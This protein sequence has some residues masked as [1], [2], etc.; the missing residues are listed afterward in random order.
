VSEATPRR[1][2]CDECEQIRLGKDLDAAATTVAFE[3][4]LKKLRLQQ[5]NDLAKLAAAQINALDIA[6][7][8]AT[9]DFQKAQWAAESE[10]NKLF[11]QTVS[12]VARNSIERSRDSAKYVQTA[13]VAIAGL[14]SGLLGLVFSITSN[15]LPIRGVYATAFLGLAVALATAYLAFIK[16]T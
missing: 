1:R 9:T 2:V 3:R 12:D 10:L 8:A 15:P 13:A 11:H 16:R 6:E 4:E 14:Y 5:Q 7:D